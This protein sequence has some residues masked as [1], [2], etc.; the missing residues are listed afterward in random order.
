MKLASLYFTKQGEAI[1]I[2]LKNRLNE[3]V[4]CYSKKNYKKNLDRIYSEYQGIIFVCSTG[5]AVRIS[6]PFLQSKTSDPAIVVVDDLGRYAISLVSGH[7]GGANEL[8][9]KIATC[10]GCQPIITTATDSRGIEAI[11]LFAQKHDYII[12]D[13]ASVKKITSLMIEGKNIQ[14]FTPFDE[15]IHYTH[16]VERNPDACI[17]VSYLDPI[18]CNVPYCVLRPRVLHVGI[19]CRKGKSKEEILNAI[20]HAFQVNHLNLKCIKSVA[21]IELK[22]D[23]P[24]IIQ[25]CEALNCELQIFNNHEIEK[26]QH[27][28]KA[29]RFVKQHTGVTSVSEPCAYLASKKLL[30]HKIA[31][32]GI[33]VSIGVEP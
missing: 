4:D 19:G 9:R 1:S 12:E 25:T 22:K 32:N 5:I 16:L 10:L 20:Q 21:T 26:I 15:K 33:T 23:E 14:L 27:Y 7:L 2:Q 29:S 24:G 13:F 31:M 17:Y 11:D 18:A 6:A 8:T 28:F 3:T 30:V